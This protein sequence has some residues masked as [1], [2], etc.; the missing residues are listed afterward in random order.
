MGY[1]AVQSVMQKSRSKGSAR[2]VLMVIAT[3]ANDKTLQCF[4]GR[5][6]LCQESAMEER[7]LIYAIKKL[8][9]LK[10]LKVIRGEGRGNQ[11]H[12]ELTIGQPKK[13]Q[14]LATGEQE[15]AAEKD[16]KSGKNAQESPAKKGAKFGKKRAQKGAKTGKRQSRK[17]AKFGD[18]GCKISPER[19]QDL[20]TKGAK[21][22]DT[23]KEE[24]SCNHQEPSITV[25]GGADA[26]TEISKNRAV[27]LFEGL[28]VS[29]GKY[30]A[31][32]NWKDG[33]F[34]Q[35]EALLKR[36]RKPKPPKLPWTLTE[37]RF[38]HALTQ[39]LAT[40]QLGHTFADLCTRFSF[41]FRSAGD[42]FNKPAGADG[43]VDAK[44]T[45]NS[46]SDARRER[47]EQAADRIKAGEVI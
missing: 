5:D 20:A 24:P 44:T 26:P 43:G 23:C 12:Y 47:W 46:A 35:W 27:E 38:L 15:D 40:P 8:E 10:E 18:K 3:H 36:C 28:L 32:Y 16:A 11:S 4:P 2:L 14:N 19:V 13:V 25:M 22:G 21:S 7:N 30:E 31:P 33:D 45:A 41:F 37:D 1:K 17:G 39:Y 9:D 29:L 6:L 42:R 34:V